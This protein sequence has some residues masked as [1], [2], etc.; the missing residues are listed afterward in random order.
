M[1]SN[2]GDDRFGQCQARTSDEAHQHHCFY[3]EEQEN[4]RFEGGQC[5]S[6]QGV[7]SPMGTVFLKPRQM[8]RT[9]KCL[10]LMMMPL[11]HQCVRTL[12]HP[13]KTT[14]ECWP[15]LK[16]ISEFKGSEYLHLHLLF[17]TYVF[18]PAPSKSGIPLAAGC[19]PT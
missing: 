6:D 7:K 1:G 16:S 18:P 17:R 9:Q 11:S 10:C 3:Q 5:A 19:L 2:K 12:Q 15:E 13:N 4:K 14:L 8:P